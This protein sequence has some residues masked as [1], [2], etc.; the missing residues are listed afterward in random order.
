MPAD[1]CHGQRRCRSTKFKALHKEERDARPLSPGKRTITTSHDAFGYFTHE[2]C[3]KFGTSGRFGRS[4]SFGR[5][6][7]EDHRS[8]PTRQAL[9]V[10]VENITNPRLM[11]PMTSV[12]GLVSAAARS[13]MSRI[14][15]RQQAAGRKRLDIGVL[16]P[17]RLLDR[18][19]LH[20]VA[21]GQDTRAVHDIKLGLVHARPQ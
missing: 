18:G 7:L 11:T 2:Y 1:C 13:T 15:A 9:A 3:P 5:R 16:E 21:V 20:A 19:M 14:L 12:T 10:F 8:Y 17:R 4:R 6:G